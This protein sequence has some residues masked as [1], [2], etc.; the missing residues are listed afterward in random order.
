MR[1]Q[2]IAWQTFGA[3][4][5]STTTASASGVPRDANAGAEVVFILNGP[6]KPAGIQHGFDKHSGQQ[7]MRLPDRNTMALSVILK[8]TAEGEVSST[9][10]RDP[11]IETRIEVA[12]VA[13]AAKKSF[14]FKPTKIS[15]RPK[16]PSVK[17]SSL[18][19]TLELYEEAPSIDFTD[20]SLKDGGF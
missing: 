5:L 17:F 3:I 6:E 4:F 15:A 1:F 2:A 11:S 19:P 8:K 16:L 14:K 20:K 12:H 9:I 13:E 10:H 18:S 7:F